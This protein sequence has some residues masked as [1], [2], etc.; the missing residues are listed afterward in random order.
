[1]ALKAN[2]VNNKAARYGEGMLGKIKYL[3]TGS[4]GHISE[5]DPLYEGYSSFYPWFCE[6]KYRLPLCTYYCTRIYATCQ[7]FTIPLDTY[8]R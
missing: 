6:K 7:N 2:D 3:L 8:P 1:M 4:T 5:S